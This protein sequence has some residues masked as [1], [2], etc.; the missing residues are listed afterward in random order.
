MFL[1]GR[2]TELEKHSNKQVKRWMNIPQMVDHFKMESLVSAIVASKLKAENSNEWRANPDA[3]D[4]KN[5]REFW[6][7]VLHEQSTE[8]T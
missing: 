4:D 7:T 2:L 6:V 1:F 3:P 5:G 8:Y